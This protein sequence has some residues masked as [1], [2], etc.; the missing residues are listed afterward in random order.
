MVVPIDLP[1]T[2]MLAPGI[3]S[4]VF[5]SFTVPVI[6]VWANITEPIK[7]TKIILNSFFIISF[8]ILVNVDAKYN[9]FLII[10]KNVIKKA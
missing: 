6:E 5:A 4:P 9:F 3:G 1:K 2:L 8:I 10:V 7:S